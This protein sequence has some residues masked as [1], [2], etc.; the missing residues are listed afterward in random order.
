VPDRLPAALQ[1]AELV[2]GTKKGAAYVIAPTHAV[3]AAD[4]HNKLEIWRRL[5]TGV[6]Q[7]EFESAIND[8]IAEWEAANGGPQHQ[9]IPV[10]EG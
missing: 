2:G 9:A 4:L 8:F 7:A 5:P 1:N 6:P 3:F 10:A